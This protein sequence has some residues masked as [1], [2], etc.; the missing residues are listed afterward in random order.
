[1]TPNR[2]DNLIKK[3]LDKTATNEEIL[4]L[5]NWYRETANQDAEFPE[6]E[7]EVY[8]S[9]LQQLNQ[10][11]KPRHAFMGYKTW[12]AAASVILALGIGGILYIN[13]N[14]TPQ[15]QYAEVIKVGGNKAILTLADGSKISLTDAGMGRIASEN[16]TQISQLDKGRVGY[17]TS[18]AGTDG[19]MVYNTIETPVGGQYQVILPDGT[20]IWLNAMSSIKF[21]VSFSSAAERVVELT[22]EAYFDVKHDERQPFKVISGGHVVEDIGT[23]FNIQA[24]NGEDNIKTTLVQGAA[25]VIAGNSLKLLKPGYQTQYN[26]TLALNKANIDKEIA[27]K[28]GYFLF[29]EDSLEDIMKVVSRWYNIKYVFQEESLRNEPYSAI[30]KRFSNISALL[31]VMQQTGGNVDF[32][33]QGTTIIIAR[34][35]AN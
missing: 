24:Y 35:K 4:E 13:L 33:I 20:K 15:P 8:Q 25:R 16:G 6:I 32:K 7:D 28:K 30:T 29:E 3:Y 5:T 18:A 31:G 34:K 27:W 23:Q 1:M 10:V 14:K 19:K 12:L 21:P 17:Q 9:M 26:G 11:T 2:I 22:G